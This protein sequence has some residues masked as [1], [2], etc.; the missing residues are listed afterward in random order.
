MVKQISVFL[1]NKEGRLAEVTRTLADNGINIRAL[2]I[3][4]TT[5]FGILRIIVDDPRKAYGALQDAGY[6]V[7]VKDVL[8]IGIK[9]VPGALANVL[10]ALSGSGIV[11]EYMYA[12]LG[13]AGDKAMVVLKVSDNEKTVSALGKLGVPVI[14]ADVLYSL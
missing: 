2:S 14:D 5:D 3:A 12:F 9:D 6:A 13:K 1:E 10:D 11:I 7:S 4:D 8:A